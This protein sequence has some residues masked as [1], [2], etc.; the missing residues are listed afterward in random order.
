MLVPAMLATRLLLMHGYADTWRQQPASA[1]QQQPGQAHLGLGHLLSEGMRLASTAD[2]AGGT[3]NL[4]AYALPDPAVC[5]NGCPA[6]V[7]VVVRDPNV[8]VVTL[9][10]LSAPGGAGWC[11]NPEACAWEANQPW[12]STNNQKADPFCSV[13]A[14]PPTPLSN[15]GL[16]NTDCEENP[17]FCT[18]SHAMISGCDLAMWMGDG[19]FIY[20]GKN[21]DGNGTF[22]GSVNN[23]PASWL[24]GTTSVHF[25]G[26]SILRKSIA[27]LASLG[28]SKATHV[29][30]TG[31]VWSGTALVYHAD[32]IGD[33]VRGAVPNLKQFKV[34]PV[35]PVH[36]KFMTMMCTTD[37][38]EQACNSSAAVPPDC[39][40]VAH[41]GPKCARI[42][43]YDGHHYV[44]TWLDSSLPDLYNSTQFASGHTGILSSP[45]PPVKCRPTEHCADGSSCPKSGVC[46][47]TSAG[48]VGAKCMW[49]NESAPYVKSDMFVVQAMPGVS[50]VASARALRFC[51]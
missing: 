35:D 20:H 9:G 12:N 18:A 14:P 1:Y 25:R 22:N 50:R 16:Q 10:D 7:Q 4:T 41:L 46:P 5:I 23:Q 26:Q 45:P 21:G 31:F 8:W 39:D 32:T 27:K 24:P 43:N 3:P 30:V 6:H 2:P 11:I 15:G 38:M 33:L 51:C 48:C 36:P 42:P 28:M 19:T 29:L 37:V 47:A 49:F 34:L 40:E 13:T 44:G 17:V